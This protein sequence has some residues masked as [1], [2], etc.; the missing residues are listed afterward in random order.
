MLRADQLASLDVIADE[1]LLEQDVAR[2]KDM[3]LHLYMHAFYEHDLAPYVP[4][5]LAFT[6]ND[7]VTQRRVSQGLAVYAYDAGDASLVETLLASPRAT[8]V[9]QVDHRRRVGAG[10]IA[11][12]IAFAGAAAPTEKQLAFR[13]L[14]NLARFGADLTPAL[15]LLC[16]ALGTKPSGRGLKK[17]DLDAYA[18]GA[19]STLERSRL[20]AE[21]EHRA[22]TSKGVAAYLGALKA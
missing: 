20:L 17:I 16:G 10:P 18:R 4:R 8:H 7:Y 6:S 9:L 15:D 21:L 1:L 11:A 19:L 14:E 5:L 3:A 12:I 22:P 2:A 13:A